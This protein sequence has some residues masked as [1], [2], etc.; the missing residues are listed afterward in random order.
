MWRSGIE[1]GNQQIETWIS[2]KCSPRACREKK[3][4][5]L[6]VNRGPWYNH[7]TK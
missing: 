4:S 1:F 7:Y 5:V 2:T 3:K 6:A